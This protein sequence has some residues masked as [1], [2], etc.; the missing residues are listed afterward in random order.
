MKRK[1]HINQHKIKANKKTGK[2]DP[3]ITVK[4]YKDNTYMS[5][6]YLRDDHDKVVAKIIYSPDKPLSCGATVWIET[7][8]NVTAE[9]HIDYGGEPVELVIDGGIV[10]ALTFPVDEDYD[11]VLDI[12]HKLAG[13]DTFNAV[14]E[15]YAP[16]PT[17]KGKKWKPIHMGNP[18][19][20]GD[21]GWFAIVD[22]GD[23]DLMRKLYPNYKHVDGEGPDYIASWVLSSG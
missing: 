22:T 4:T 17:K 21:R 3:V 9:E 16:H 8:L 11:K 23:V 6:A 5:Q 18:E 15:I 13:D 19:R 1:I 2:R 20:E 10:H 7:E 12:S 14:M